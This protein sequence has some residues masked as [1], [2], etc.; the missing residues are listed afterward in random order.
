MTLKKIITLNLNNLIPFVKGI[1]YE[2]GMF[3]YL[4]HAI[5]LEHFVSY[6]LLVYLLLNRFLF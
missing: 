6:L 3:Y 2:D 5:K 1:S 4:I